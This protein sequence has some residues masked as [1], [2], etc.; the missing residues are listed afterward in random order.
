MQ[1]NQPEAQ[2]TCES[3]ALQ[4]HQQSRFALGI[5]HLPQ[6]MTSNMELRI[7][8]GGLN[9]IMS[10]LAQA[11]EPPADIYSLV[12]QAVTQFGGI[13]QI[14][15]SKVAQSINQWKPKRRARNKR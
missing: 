3:L 7:Q 4:L 14:P 12:E 1:C 10:C 5:T 6:Q 8:C 2:T 15:Y 11:P 13:E 9:G